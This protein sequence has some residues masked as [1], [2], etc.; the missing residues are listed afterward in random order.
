MVHHVAMAR[1]AATCY[2]Q[3]KTGDCRSQP[4]L[5]AQLLNCMSVERCRA[6]RRGEES[7]HGRDP[8]VIEGLKLFASL[9]AIC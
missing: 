4:V 7:Y 9:L 5:I 3:T 6:G 8:G 1:L 2:R